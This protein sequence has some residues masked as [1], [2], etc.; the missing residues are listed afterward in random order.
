[1][2]FKIKFLPLKVKQCFMDKSKGKDITLAT[3]RSRLLRCLRSFLPA[4]YELYALS[5]HALSP[6]I[7]HRMVAREG[8]QPMAHMPN[9]NLMVDLG[10]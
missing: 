6:C 4:E 2:C 10:V 5:R 3:I 1:M 8:V 9:K 7:R